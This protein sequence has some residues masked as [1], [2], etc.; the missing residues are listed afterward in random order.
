MLPMNQL[1]DKRRKD[2]TIL[3]VRTHERMLHESQ[4]GYAFEGNV[5]GCVLSQRCFVS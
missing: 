1:S 5:K 2:S 4:Y 3:A